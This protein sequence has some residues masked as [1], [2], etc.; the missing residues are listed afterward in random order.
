M[1]EATPPEATPRSTPAWLH[2]VLGERAQP[3][4][5]A[6]ILAF[7]VAAG[8][9]IV[10][11]LAPTLDLP[12][13][14]WILAAAVVGDIAAG[15]IANFTASTN[16]FYAARP[17]NRWVF[18]AVH[19]HPL[20]VAVVLG[21]PLRPAVFTW[22]ATIGAA[23]L[24]NVMSG[25][26]QQRVVAAVALASVWLV[27]TSVR[28]PGPLLAVDGLFALKVIYA[29]A[30]DH[31]VAPRDREG[32][33]LLSHRDRD[34]LVALVAAAFANDPMFVAMLGHLAPAQRPHARAAWVAAVFD[35]NR[36]LGGAAYGVFDRGR[37]VGAMILERPLR[38]GGSL[39]QLLAVCPF[40]PVLVRVGARVAVS[41]N[42]YSR[43]TRRA[44][45]R[46]PH[47][48]LTMVAVSPT[49]QGRGIGRRLIEHAVA[50]AV[51][52]G[53]S[54][55]VA[56]DTELKENVA[57]YQAWGFVAGPT[58]TVSMPTA[59]VTV[60]PMLREVRRQSR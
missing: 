10:H 47:H 43:D 46:E 8:W 58:W 28:G 6:M 12:L 16:D 23:T 49:E 1:T 36:I 25:R 32:L 33:A 40:V 22:L 31:G 53:R 39:R 17:R 38:W 13:W 42:G 37:L 29:F 14:R 15:C 50:Q 18:I 41:I 55:G 60:T 30:V 5:V 7:G 21:V 2:D 24:V 3:V 52:D 54:R 20:L 44:A 11:A 27:V 19:V 45:P 9:A 51:A 59:S 56:L 34:E 4:E 48:Y 35:M 26:P 57:R